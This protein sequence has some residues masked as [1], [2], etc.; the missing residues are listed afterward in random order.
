MQT[1]LLAAMIA[2]WMVIA[3]LAMG[4]AALKQQVDHVI[5]T[6]DGSL[7]GMRL[8]SGSLP[9]KGGVFLVVTKSCLDCVSALSDLARLNVPNGGT[10]LSKGGPD[11]SAELRNHFDIVEDA[12]LIDDLRVKAFPWVVAVQADGTVIA[13]ERY[14]SHQRFNE[15]LKGA[16]NVTEYSNQ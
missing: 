3:L 7:V 2:S 1:F 14:S 16:R 11:I 4:F 12:R 5:R 10:I 8:R 15:L 9:P 6:P 13:H